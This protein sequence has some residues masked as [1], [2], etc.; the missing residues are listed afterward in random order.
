MTRKHLVLCTVLFASL[1]ML[2]GCG[3]LP[4]WLGGT[5]TPSFAPLPAIDGGASVIITWQQSLGG[6]QASL[7]TPARVGERVYAAHPDGTVHIF[8]A[9]GGA[10]LGRFSIPPGKGS[11]VGGIGASERLLVL[12][13]NRGLALAFDPDGRLLWEAR[14]GS[15]AT[16]PAAIADGMVV[17]AVIDGSLIG[18]DAASGERKWLVQRP[19]P[20]LTLRSVSTPV[21]LRGA[22][23]FGT[24]SGR[25][26]A[27]DLRTG[28]IGWEATV[29]NPRGTSELE[30]L[31]DVLGTPS[32]DRERICAAAYQG[33]V[34]CFDQ[35][36]GRTIWNRD[37]SSLIGTVLDERH[38]YSVDEKGIVQ[39]MDK[40]TGATVWRRD[41]LAG[42]RASGLAL[43]APDKLAVQDLQG[44]LHLLERNSGRILARGL[45][46]G[47]AA[48]A[49]LVASGDAVL[50]QAQSGQLLAVT[51]R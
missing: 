23:F 12:S 19:L 15:E 31:I 28:A 1:L 37:F 35:A 48:T 42:R 45:G 27:L 44:N 36:T 16:S 49:P 26:L 11:L 9:Q 5:R 46:E 2:A 22:V 40:S 24:P 32:F 7:L 17:L 8:N 41:A 10:S 50:V 14:L 21:A 4:T 29:A 51:A 3:S 18:L 13:T 20:A 6:R 38:V 30:R 39:A 34:A 25:L 33:R 43:L 47:F